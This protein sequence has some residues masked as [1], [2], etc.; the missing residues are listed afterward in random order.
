[1]RFKKRTIKRIPRKKKRKFK[2]YLPLDN[3]GCINLPKAE[4]PSKDLISVFTT[5]TKCVEGDYLIIYP[6]SSD[7]DLLG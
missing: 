3:Y 4:L 2:G 5:F 1:M 6:P 7:I